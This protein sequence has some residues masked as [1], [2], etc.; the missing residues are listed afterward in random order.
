MCP[1]QVYACKKRALKRTK[2]VY[3]PETPCTPQTPPPKPNEKS[4]TRE[5]IY[6]S[7]SKCTTGLTPTSGSHL[8]N[9]SHLSNMPPMTSDPVNLHT[10]S[11]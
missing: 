11:R 9:S 5:I 10:S 8:S 6:A 1:Q 7:K 2:K 3:N 4:D